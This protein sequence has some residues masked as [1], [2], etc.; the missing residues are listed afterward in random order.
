MPDVNAT[1]ETPETPETPAATETPDAPET[2]GA[3][4]AGA[5]ETEPK[6]GPGAEPKPEPRRFKVKVE[7]EEMEVDEQE[8]LKGYQLSKAGYKRLEQVATLRKQLEG[9]VQDFHKD[10]VSTLKKLAEENE[11]GPKFREAVE[12]F[13]Y[14]ELER[15]R[16]DPKER[17][18]VEAQEKLRRV[19][20]EKKTLAERQR[21]EAVERQREYWS[22]KFDEDITSALSDPEV[23]LPKTPTTVARM[24]E[25]M[26]K[27][28]QNN[29]PVDARD[30]AR[31]VRD[32]YI[33]AQREVVAKLDGE[34]LM[35][36]LGED[37]AKKIRAY[38]TAKLKRPVAAPGSPAA[39]TATPGARPA[40]APAKPGAP[41]PRRPMSPREFDEFLRS[42]R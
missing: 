23:G 32:E 19:E 20:E 36:W 5:P 25:L 42:V 27:G 7:G 29:I 26:A 15:E 14:A 11:H 17:A 1:P 22:K 31:L 24:A 30:V 12:K 8:L 35:R 9:F 39:P 2:P 3:A 37:V 10:P 40:G 16:M 41:E 18:L 21:Q 38:E 33:Q 34:G 4:G 28:I 6:D 13:L